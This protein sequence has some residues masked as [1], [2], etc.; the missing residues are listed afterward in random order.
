MIAERALVRQFI[1]GSRVVDMRRFDLNRLD[2]MSLGLNREYP[3]CPD[4]S[5]TKT[6]A[7]IEQYLATLPR[8]RPAS[9]KG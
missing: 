8:G 5:D 3:L 6:N 2:R 7:L 1:A 9:R 4:Y